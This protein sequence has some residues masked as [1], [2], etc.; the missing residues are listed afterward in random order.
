[1]LRREPLR[2]GQAR[3]QGDVLADRS[4]PAR[5]VFSRAECT[6]HTLDKQFRPDTAIRS[7]LPVA[8]VPHQAGPEII[9]TGWGR[10]SA[11]ELGS[12]QG[13][14]RVEWRDV[15]RRLSDAAADQKARRR[16]TDRMLKV[17]VG[18]KSCATEAVEVGIRSLL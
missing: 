10:R 14:S 1:L 15:D 2:E 16:S 17:R 7:D 5:E 18:S 11:A 6:A 4:S 13:G 9:G 3:I 8:R 12:E